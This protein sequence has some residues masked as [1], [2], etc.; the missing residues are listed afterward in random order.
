[1]RRLV[2]NDYGVFIGVKGDRVIVKKSGEKIVEIAAGNISQ[3]IVAS[4]GVSMSSAFL[5]LMLKHKV[6]FVLL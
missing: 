3:V 4:R 5:R 1:M 2:V 6:D